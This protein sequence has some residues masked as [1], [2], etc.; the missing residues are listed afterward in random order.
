MQDLELRESGSPSS[1]DDA[2]PER[3]LDLTDGERGPSIVCMACRAQVTTAASRID[4]AGAHQH[5]R[6]NPGGYVFTIGCFRHARGCAAV[7]AASSDFPWFP[8]YDWQVALCRACRAHL[9][10]R[11]SAADEAFYGLRLD[12]VIE[13]EDEPDA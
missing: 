5:T 12:A 6:M 2:R 1:G 11:F 10:W 3:E 9:G 8:H 13:A 4:V 7:G